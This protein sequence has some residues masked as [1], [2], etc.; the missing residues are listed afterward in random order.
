MTEPVRPATP[1][2]EDSLEGYVSPTRRRMPV[3]R[4]GFTHHAFVADFDFYITGNVQPDGTLGEVFIKGAGK[5]GSS[6]QGLM[7]A[8]A[9]MFSIGLQY[10]AELGMLV[11]KFS[12]MRFEP[13]GRTE[14][15][16][17]PTATSI[18]D[19]TCRW[20]GLRFGDEAL[21]REVREMGR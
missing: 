7:D 2:A 19:Y 8:F 16:D 21:Q 13:E 17:I 12:H 9:T 20:L 6:V 18:V 4:G 1:T 11:R 10:G 15:P 14:H 5:E 3:E